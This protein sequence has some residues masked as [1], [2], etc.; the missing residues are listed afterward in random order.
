[1][2]GGLP[3]FP[4][5]KERCSCLLSVSVIVGY[6]LRIVGSLSD[7]SSVCSSITGPSMF[8]CWTEDAL[9]CLRAVYTVDGRPW[10]HVT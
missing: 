2:G 4:L 10:E 1:M 9:N 7:L 6:V 3:S 8:V 5:W